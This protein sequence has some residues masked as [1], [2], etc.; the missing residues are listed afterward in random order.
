M[1]TTSTATLTPSQLGNLRDQLTAAVDDLT[2]Q[3]ALLA[4]SEADIIEAR[5]A[6]DQRTKSEGDADL[7]G[8]ERNLVAQQTTTLTEGLSDLQDALVRLSAGTFGICTRC[9]QPIP[10]ERLLARPRAELCVPC[11]SRR[12]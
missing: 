1:N 11:A 8:V 12:R 9:H 6:V 5:V 3:L 7:L 2:A 10:V 4:Q